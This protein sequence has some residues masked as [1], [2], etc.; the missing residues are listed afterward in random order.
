MQS[1][2]LDLEGDLL[3]LGN[4][5]MALTVSSNATLE[6]RNLGTGINKSIVL[7]D[8]AIVLNAAGANTLLGPIILST[9]SAAQP[10]NDAI[11]KGRELIAEE[12]REARFRTRGLLAAIGFMSLI[13]AG[14][15]LKLR[16]IGKRRIT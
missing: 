12:R 15:A 7:N 11:A 14:I 8:G 13:A 1:G 4:A 6:F 16:E 9:N 2:V 5:N 10:G 3:G